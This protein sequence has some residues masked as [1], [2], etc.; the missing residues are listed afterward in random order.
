MTGRNPNSSP[1][2]P[3]FTAKLIAPKRLQPVLRFLPRPSVGLNADCALRMRVCLQ[4][5]FPKVRLRRDGLP[6][7]QRQPT[8]HTR[9]FGGARDGSVLP[10]R[11]DVWRLAIG[12]Q[13]LPCGNPP[14]KFLVAVQWTFPAF[15]R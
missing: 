3:A 10:T 1:A 5:K 13:L 4:G 2:L 7:P 6:S 9:P 11:R 12:F 8:P 15:R 14:E